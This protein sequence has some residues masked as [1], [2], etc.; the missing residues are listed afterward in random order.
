MVGVGAMSG[1]GMFVLT[2]L[3]AE[4][5]GHAAILGWRS[6]GPCPGSRAWPTLHVRARVLARAAGTRTWR[7]YSLAWTHVVVVHGSVFETLH[8]LFRG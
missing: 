4:I 2:G 5:A 8:Q 1:A 6:T 3:R 7:R